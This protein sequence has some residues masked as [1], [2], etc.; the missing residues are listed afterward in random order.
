MAYGSPDV[1]ALRSVPD[2]EPGPNEVLIRV[3]A[4][5][6]T[7]ADTMMRKGT[8]R[9]ARL[10]LGIFKPRQVT[11]GTGFSGI[12]EAVGQDV[13]RFA[14]GDAVMGESIFGGGANCEFVC[15]PQSGLLLSK[16]AEINFSAAA[17]V[18]DGALTAYHFLNTLGEL[19][20]GQK[21]LVIGA[22]GSLGSAAVQLAKL[23]GARVT[24]TCS[25]RNIEFVKSLGADDVIDYMDSQACIP[26][27]RFDI[28]FDSVGKLSPR[29]GLRALREH[30]RYLTPVLGLSALLSVA[31]TRFFGTRRTMFSATG[32][33]P[34]KQLMTM[35]RKV[36][37]HLASGELSLF[38]DRE[39]RLADIAKAHAYVDTGHKRGNV[40]L[41]S[42]SLPSS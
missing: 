23:S 10:F 38:V 21:V 24:G 8:P 7:A 18:C 11:P 34:V 17:S 41:V 22:A 33:L 32:L 28:V 13:S 27:G 16:P 14:P 19:R 15:M 31:M 9:F 1:L 2:P 39:Y 4:S 29:L 12:V 30:G 42:E 26:E 35:L 5:A 20:A 37:E 6:V 40:V 3:F 36:S 25:T